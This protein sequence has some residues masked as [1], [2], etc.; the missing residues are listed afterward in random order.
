MST[1]RLEIDLGKIEQNARKLVGWLAS[2]GIG[3]TGIVKATLGS[4]AIAQALLRAGVKRLGDS[5]IENIEE[6]RRAHICAPII[7]VRSPMLSQ[8]GRV[9]RSADASFNTELDVIAALSTAARHEART[10]GVLL[11]VELGDLRE[12]VM[13]KDLLDTVKRMLRLPNIAL[14]GIGTNLACR[15]GVRPDISNMA[16]LSSL[17]DAIDAA[18]ADSLG[19]PIRVVSGGNSA[20]LDWAMS[21][22]DPGRIDDLR[23]GESILLGREPLGRRAIDGLSTD[24]IRLVAEV[25]ESNRKPSQPW[26]SV[27][28]GAFGEVPHGPDRGWVRQA[29]LGIG[30]QDIDPDDIHAPPGIEVR[31]AS[32]DHLII[33]CESRHLEVGTEITFEL[34]YSALLRAMTSPH[35]SRLI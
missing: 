15:N 2:R 8:V 23:L 20:N 24:A 25:I 32:S 19:G 7:L 35:V 16:E 10:H 6:L 4:P 13:P 28:Q 5:R 21:D 22:S 17:A 1:P 14:S 18:F 34:G 27:A 31:S 11:M 9:V 30:R 33:E 3:V 26:G 12:G 29:I